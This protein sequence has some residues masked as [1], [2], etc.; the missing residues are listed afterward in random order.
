MFPK[1]LI[2][3]QNIADCLAAAGAVERAGW[4]LVHSLWQFAVVAALAAAAVAV[5]HGL[6]PVVRHFVL[7]CGLGAMAALPV[8]TWWTVDVA[9]AAAA[10]AAV[11]S[12]HSAAAS[13]VPAVSRG[14]M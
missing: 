3:I 10:R 7:A 8:V 4:V 9:P 6:G 14:V 13:S 12:P 11:A 1:E 2:V 5:L